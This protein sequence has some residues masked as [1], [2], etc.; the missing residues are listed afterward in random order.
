MKHIGEREVHLHSF[1]TSELDGR[2]WLT[3]HRTHGAQRAC[4]EA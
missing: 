1:V 4:I 2:G 3:S